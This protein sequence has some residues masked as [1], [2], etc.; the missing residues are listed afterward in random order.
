MMKL[1]PCVLTTSEHEW[2]TN[3][4]H[5]TDVVMNAMA[6]NTIDG[7]QTFMGDTVKIKEN[8]IRASFGGRAKFLLW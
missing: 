7:M 6:V 1:M 2:T 4:K 8:M 3:M 5:V